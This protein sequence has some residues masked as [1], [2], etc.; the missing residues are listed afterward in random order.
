MRGKRRKKDEIHTQNYVYGP[1]RPLHSYH[2][3]VN[4]RIER[5]RVQLT[6]LETLFLKCERGWFFSWVDSIPESRTFCTL[7]GSGISGLLWRVP[8]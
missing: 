5:T 3:N 4:E 8:S 1:N 2:R 6:I 7:L